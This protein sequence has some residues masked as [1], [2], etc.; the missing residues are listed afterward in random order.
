[1]KLYLKPISCSLAVHI[2]LRELGLDFEPIVAA[3]VGDRLEA[4]G[5]ALADIHPTAAVPILELDN[6]DVMTEAG[7]MLEYLSSQL[8]GDRLAPAYG[9]AEYWEFR[10]LMN[11][12]ATDI[13]K[14]YGPIFNP[15]VSPEMKEAWLG[16]LHRRLDYLNTYIGVRDTLLP[17]GLSVADFYLWVM[18]FWCSYVGVDT[19]DWPNLHRYF[20]Q[21]SDRPSVCDALAFEQG[22]QD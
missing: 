17:A 2:A 1:M 22:G 14:N 8:G 16:R 7:V 4:D 10:Q 15:L 6:G 13:H 5:R 19:A 9:T 20:Q 21:L 11:F 18:L 3:K 12:I